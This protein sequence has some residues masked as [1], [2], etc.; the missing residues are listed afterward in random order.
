M[1]DPFGEAALA[2]TRA[3]QDELLALLP[4]S[5]ATDLADVLGRTDPSE[6][7]TERV[8]ALIE[9]VPEAQALVMATMRELA[10]DDLASVALHQAQALVA[11]WDGDLLLPE[12]VTLESLRPALAQ[13][14]ELNPI[15]R[16]RTVTV[17]D[18]G[19][20]G[21]TSRRFVNFGFR[22]KNLVELI[23]GAGLTAL[24]L[25]H[26]LT[27]ALLVFALAKVVHD[28]ITVELST[29]EATVVWALVRAK[30]RRG[31]W[32]TVDELASCS[33]DERERFGMN[34]LKQDRLDRILETLLA[35]K[36]VETAEWGEVRCYRLIEQVVV[37]GETDR[38][39]R[40]ADWL[41]T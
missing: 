37:D 14:I 18:G 22:P 28:S 6:A 13:S 23:G 31:E 10:V 39:W 15:D 9:T 34:P 30:P 19:A 24:T 29:D 41:F 4:P 35:M 16:E 33:I 40:A 1:T 3:V 26:V 12:H 11:A 38:A 27:F 2:A 36:V 21:G 5:A 8:L 32:I 25:P 17:S 7:E 20:D